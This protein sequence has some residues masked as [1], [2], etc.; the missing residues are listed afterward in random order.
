MCGSDF[1]NETFS[2]AVNALRRQKTDVSYSLDFIWYEEP[3]SLQGIQT[4][5]V[6]CQERDLY[7]C[8]CVCVFV[9]VSVC[10]RE[11]EV[12]GLLYSLLVSEFWVCILFGWYTIYS[13]L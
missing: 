5:Q 2:C 13:G 9:C 1:G 4:L 12:V 6:K 8:V 11:R 3:H 7:V 10:A